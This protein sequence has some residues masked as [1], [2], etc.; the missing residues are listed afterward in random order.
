[1]TPHTRDIW[2]QSRSE[3]KASEAA[4]ASVREKSPDVLLIPARRR[5]AR[6]GHRMI[7]SFEVSNFRCFTTLNLTGLKKVNV[8]TGSN[9]SGKSALLEAIYLG[10]NA[11]APAFQNVATFRGLSGLP[12]ITGPLG[13]PLGLQGPQSLSPYF[14]NLFRVSQNAEGSLEIAKK[15]EIGFSDSDAT[16]YKLDVSYQST[17]SEPIPVGRTPI[18]IGPQVPIILDRVK[19]ATTVN[20]VTKVNIS[21]N[22]FGQMQQTPASPFGPTTFIFS[23]E[24][25]Y[26][27]QDNITWFSQLK[28]RNSAE[29]TISFFRKE[30][31]FIEDIEVLAPAGVNGLYAKLTDGS[32]RRISNVSSGIY[33]IVSFLLAIAN[34]P[35]GIVII[36]EIE[37]GIYYDKYSALWRILYQFAQ[38]TDTQLFISSHSAECLEALPPVIGDQVN[39]FSLIRTERENGSCIARHISGTS[40][41]AALTLWG[42]HKR[43]QRET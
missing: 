15:I 29:T 22:Q 31:A 34:S 30:F 35:K 41:K 11:T 23:A 28:E 36:D 24:F 4:S 9:A 18:G 14:D 43:S 8:I 21:I 7:E 39:D 2:R 26:A 17:G 25:G 32:R 12:I 19:T 5:L 6:V 38:D 16:R 1:M 27:E 10:A 37:N 20:Q 42:G 13:L 40:L 33:K 3:A